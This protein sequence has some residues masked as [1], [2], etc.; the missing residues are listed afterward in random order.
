MPKENNLPK[1]RVICR[2]VVEYWEDFNSEEE[3]KAKYDGLTRGDCESLY[4][5][6]ERGG[7]IQDVKLIEQI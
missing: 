1:F 7:G 6:K 4:S 2:T 3:A 5:M